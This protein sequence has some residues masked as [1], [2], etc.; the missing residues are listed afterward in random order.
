MEII[1]S[2][3]FFNIGRN[4]HHVGK[5]Y[6][7]LVKP[8]VAVLFGENHNY[9]CFY[10]TQKSD[11]N[12]EEIQKITTSEDWIS[13]V[14]KFF[15]KS[16]SDQDELLIK[17]LIKSAE[18]E[19]EDGFFEFIEKNGGKVVFGNPNLIIQEDLD[20]YIV[21]QQTNSGKFSI[22]EERINIDGYLVNLKE[23]SSGLFDENHEIVV[24]WKR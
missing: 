24:Y 1:Y 22:N 6:F 21:K 3:S 8:G 15:K 4:D 12:I 11:S 18:D 9:I 16:I 23:L 17:C 7:D 2:I 20:I 5:D 19:D 13:L 10:K 14:S